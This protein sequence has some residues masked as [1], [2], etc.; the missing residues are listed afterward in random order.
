MIRNYWTSRREWEQARI[1]PAYIFI[2]EED[3]LK[4]SACRL[5]A[6]KYLKQ[7]PDRDSLRTIY[8]TEVDGPAIVEQCLNLG[9]FQNRQ[10]LV[11]READALSAKSRKALLGYLDH[12]SPDSC[13]IL[14]SN[15]SEVKDTWVKDFEDRLEV[16]KF[17]LLEGWELIRWLLTRSREL[18]LELEEEAAQAL[19]A[20]SG[21]GLGILESELEKISHYLSEGRPR[22]VDSVLVRELAGH[23][24]Q[25][26]PD[27]LY[28][29]L[30]LGDRKHSL[31]ILQRLLDSGEDPVRLA[32]GYFY[33]LE[34]LWK[35]S[36]AFRRSYNI[37]LDKSTYYALKNQ[38][39]K[40]MA[41][42]RDDR[43]Y[44]LALRAVYEMEQKV[45]SGLGDPKTLACSMVEKITAIDSIKHKDTADGSRDHNRERIVGGT[46][47]PL[48][49][50][51]ETSDDN[52]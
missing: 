42:A 41:R 25:T 34:I 7:K 4:N 44:I 8:G 1:S 40:R 11:V 20:Q 37:R 31:T 12:P 10:V 45:K 39:M 18:G 35:A 49:G 33:Q 30:T 43:G 9:L 14:I 32:A 15:K 3:Y 17:H 21:N 5:I 23:S 27:E 29:N 24:A 13:L 51:A 6:E 28:R 50:D 19:V 47:E 22:K 36:L 52:R 16:V 38:E 46:A 26:A 2:G 48:G